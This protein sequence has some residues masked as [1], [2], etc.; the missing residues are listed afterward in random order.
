MNNIISFTYVHFL[1]YNSSKSRNLGSSSNVGVAAAR[2]VS[3]ELLKPS[4]LPSKIGISDSGSELVDGSAVL[5][6]LV[7]VFVF[8]Y[9]IECVKLNMVMAMIRMTTPPK[10]VQKMV[11]RPE[12]QFCEHIHG[13]MPMMIT[14]D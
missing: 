13:N 9:S 11:N 7:V 3:L 8:V 12:A 2:R 10:N 1:I 4:L 6:V 14:Y 5:F